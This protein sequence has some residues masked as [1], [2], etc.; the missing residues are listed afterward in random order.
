MKGSA[1][2]VSR[3]FCYV[4]SSCHPGSEQT[5]ETDCQDAQHDVVRNIVWCNCMDDVGSRQ[6]P[7]DVLRHAS[8]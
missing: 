3:L 1:Q 7:M 8:R 6:F 4:K 2:I 5:I